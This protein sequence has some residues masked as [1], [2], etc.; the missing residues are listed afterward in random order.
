[1]IR[2]PALFRPQGRGLQITEEGLALYERARQIVSITESL[3]NT[4]NPS[5]KSFSIALP[6]ILYQYLTLTLCQEF[7]EDISIYESFGN[8]EKDLLNSKLDFGFGFIP[9]LHKDLDFMKIARIRA[10]AFAMES[11]LN[12]LEGTLPMV[13]PAIDVPLN[14]LG[15]KYLDGWPENQPRHITRIANRFVTAM[16]MVKSGKVIGYFPDFTVRIENQS[17]KKSQLVPVRALANAS[18]ERDL[19]LV[20]R[21]SSEESKFMKKVVALVKKSISG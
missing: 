20:K 9:T 16:E 18:T 2:L 1:M 19:F 13:A 12:D 7:S 21:K 11:H 17:L 14:P 15:I 6:E 4:L 8:L 3:R 5:K 10:R